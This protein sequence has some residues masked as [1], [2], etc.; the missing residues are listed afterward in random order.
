M[1]NETHGK[2]PPDLFL[3][4]WALRVDSSHRIRV[5]GDTDLRPN[6]E[7]PV[8]KPRNAR[9]AE[10]RSLRTGEQ[11]RD[12]PRLLRMTHHLNHNF[13]LLEVGRHHQKILGSERRVKLLNHQRAIRDRGH[14]HLLVAVCILWTSR[15]TQVTKTGSADGRLLGSRRGQ[16]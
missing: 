11:N 14:N 10:S 15:Q 13:S 6:V 5:S 4:V 1:G 9:R 12:P 7:R 3:L 16:Q 2:G 8:A